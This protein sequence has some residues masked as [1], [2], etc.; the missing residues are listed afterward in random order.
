MEVCNEIVMKKISEIKPYVR[1]PRKN[2]KTVELLCEIIPKV[3]FNVPL[4]I[5]KNGTIVK[6]HARFNAAIKLGMT[7]L[8]CVVT[9]ADEEAIKADRLADNKISEFSEWVDEELLHELDMIDLDIDL[10]E[11]GFPTPSFD[12]VSTMEDFTEENPGET[13][14]EAERQKRYQEFLER[15]AQ[16]QAV[17]VQMTT[18]DALKKA[19]SEQR[20][21]ATPPPK[22]YKC[23]C[24]KCGHIMFV[25]A[26]D[27]WNPETG[28]GK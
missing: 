17:E 15:Q 8:P 4:V 3:G 20:T 1:N 22:Y 5:D 26:S 6:G 11:F 14:S 10:A 24:E 19:K 9:N 18:E 25:N 23:V 21:V 16:E 13:V 12:D 28:I 7:E 27:L 2:D